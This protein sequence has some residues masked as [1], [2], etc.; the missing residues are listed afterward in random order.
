[1]SY[2]LPPIAEC[3]EMLDLH[4]SLPPLA[5]EVALPKLRAA[6]DAWNTR[7]PRR[8]LLTYTTESYW[9]K[10]SEF[11]SDQQELVAF[12]IRKWAKE[13]GGRLMRE[14]WVWSNAK[15]ASYFAFERLASAGNWIPFRGN[16]NEKFGAN[17]LMKL[18]LAHVPIDKPDRMMRWGR[19]GPRTAGHSG[20]FHFSSRT[21]G[22]LKPKRR[23]E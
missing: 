19:S 14:L 22:E 1:M 6:E 9:R 10:R 17:G 2:Q 21:T 15:T 20:P 18:R 12:L 3:T 23:P 16:E 5:Q 7:D 4:H 8:V 13:L 11:V